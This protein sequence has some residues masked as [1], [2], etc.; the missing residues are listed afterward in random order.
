LACGEHATPSGGEVN[1]VTVMVAVLVTVA[2]FAVVVGL[3]WSIVRA[4][5]DPP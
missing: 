3:A 2:G 5:K 4:L 1:R